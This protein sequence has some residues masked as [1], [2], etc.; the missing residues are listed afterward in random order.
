MGAVS[1][2]LIGARGGHCQD[3]CLAVHRGRSCVSV[4]CFCSKP[5]RKVAILCIRVFFVVEPDGFGLSFGFSDLPCEMPIVPRPLIGNAVVCR[6]RLSVKTIAENR[7]RLRSVA[8][9]ERVPS[10]A[11][12]P[13]ARRILPDSGYQES[14]AVLR[15]AKRITHRVGRGRFSVELIFDRARQPCSRLLCVSEWTISHKAPSRSA[16]NHKDLRA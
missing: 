7:P 12:I 11:R 9:A 15:A 2:L 13:C 1:L 3:N 10:T 8:S 16:V 4:D 6:W 14:A 5:D